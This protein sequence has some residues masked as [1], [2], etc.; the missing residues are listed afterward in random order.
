MPMDGPC[1]RQNLNQAKGMGKTAMMEAALTVLEPV[2]SAWVGRYA[3]RSPYGLAQVA[4]LKPAVVVTGGSSGIGLALAGEF[5]R[6]G[7]VVL[8]VARNSGHL[9]AACAALPNS[10]PNQVATLVQDV[11]Q[12]E[13]WVAIE[14]WYLDV[15]VNAAGVGL[16][17]P[18]DS[19]STA[20]IEGL[21]ALNVAAL[22]RLTREAIPGMRARGHG[23]I[24]NVAS[25]GGYVPGPHQAA[26]YASK[27]YVCSLS[28]AL[29]RELSGSGVRVTVLAPG[30]VNTGFHARMGADQS[31]YRRWLPAL[32]PERVARAGVFGFLMGRPVVVAGISARLLA[33]AVWIFPHALTVPLVSAL[34]RRRK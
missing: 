19:H 10:Q 16:A 15:L 3:Q 14:G 12:A 13:A 4:Q 26:Y 28:S 22:T 31:W 1:Q 32:S 17:G 20:E 7:R 30:P 6:R 27:A 23:G 29:G 21:I 25:L 18:F 5:A 8:L 9:T 11:T 2:V 24:L 33:A 34:L